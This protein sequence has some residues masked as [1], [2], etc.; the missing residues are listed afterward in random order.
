MNIIAKTNSICS[1]FLAELRNKEVQ[2]DRMRFRANIE[3]VAEVMSYEI[4]KTLEYEEK[5]IETPVNKAKVMVLKDHIVIGSVLRAGLP[6]HEGFLKFFDMAG[7]SFVSARR[8]YN[9]D[10]TVAVRYDSVY[11]PALDGN[12]LMLVDPMLATGSSMA[13]A[14]F[15]L[16]K[17]G[18]KPKHTHIACILASKQGVE[19][20]ND[21]LKGESYTLWIGDL[22]DKLTDK[23]YIDPGM[24]DAGDLALGGK[25]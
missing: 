17:Q 18:G 19:Y 15:E 13:K 10:N 3:R 5:D 2:P 8:Y 9:P 23:F 4:S 22:D 21:K 1:Q 25:L 24:G 12:I 20:L 6:F 16:I 14:Y 11:T 7:N